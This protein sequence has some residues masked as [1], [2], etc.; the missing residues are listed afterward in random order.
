MGVVVFCFCV[1]VV[2]VCCFCVGGVVVCCCCVCVVIEVIWLLFV[3]VVWLRQ[4]VVARD[5]T[6]RACTHVRGCCSRESVRFERAMVAL[7]TTLMLPWQQPFATLLHAS[8]RKHT[9]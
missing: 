8:A 1:G 9:S 6:W 5:S 3:T 2:V 4:H 7:T